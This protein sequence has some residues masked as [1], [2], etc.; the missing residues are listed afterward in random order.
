MNSPPAS[1]CLSAA[2]PACVVFLLPVLRSIVEPGVFLWSGVIDC[3][4]IAVKS[5][6]AICQKS[7]GG[8]YYDIESLIDV[9]R[10]T[11]LIRKRSIY[12]EKIYFD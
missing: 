7:F 10:K 3:K 9:L 11:H 5:D 2:C 1:D 4:Q 8:V 12:E 6:I